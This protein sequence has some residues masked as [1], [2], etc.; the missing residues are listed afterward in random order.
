MTVEWHKLLLF[1]QL[2]QHFPLS[3]ECYVL[4]WICMTFKGSFIFACFKIPNFYGSVFWWRNHQTKNRMK[5]NL[6]T[7]NINSIKQNFTIFS[8]FLHTLVMLAR[9]PV[10]SNFSGGRGIHSVGLRFDFVGAPSRT[11]FSASD[12]R[13]SNSITFFCNRMTD[14]H[15]FSR[16]PPYFFSISVEISAS[17]RKASSASQYPLEPR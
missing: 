2:T 7:D 1:S 6:Q 15:F 12:S 11:S 14:V 17:L 5:K 9:W 4:Y 16:R 10:I 3:I 8:R 13:A